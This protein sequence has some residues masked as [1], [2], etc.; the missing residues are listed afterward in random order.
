MDHVGHVAV[1]IHALTCQLTVVFFWC[2]LHAT[3]GFAV[4]YT[5]ASPAHCSSI[6]DH[7]EW[8]NK[9]IISPM[10]WYFCLCCFIQ[11]SGVFLQWALLLSVHSCLEF[12][13]LWWN[14]WAII[15][16]VQSCLAVHPLL[17]MLSTEVSVLLFR[18]H[19]WIM[20]W[21]T[22]LLFLKL[23][24]NRSLLRESIKTHFVRIWRI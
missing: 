9:N 20:A 14:P 7:L 8:Q 3:C 6:L 17:C 16:H 18:K 1:A 24:R 2:S 5:P 11:A 22:W 10:H 4:H 19:L 23:L 21:T 15:M 12:C 13:P